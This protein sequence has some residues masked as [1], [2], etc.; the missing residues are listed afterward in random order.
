VKRREFITLLGRAAT[1]P[2]AARAQQGE[3]MRRIGVLTSL[4]ADNPQALA[5]NAAFLQGLGELGWNVGR[6]LQIDYH[7]G[8]VD[9]RR[10]YA[11]AAELV[12]R[13]PEVILA[14]GS[15]V[16]GPA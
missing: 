9:A 10:R 6:N 8:A 16:V 15:S 12:A 2:I 4:L 7:L 5:R 11:Y 3:R 1:W 13:A 14:V